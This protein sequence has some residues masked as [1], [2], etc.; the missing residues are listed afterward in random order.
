MK[1]KRKLKT[2]VILSF[3]TTLLLLSLIDLSFVAPTNS[4]FKTAGN[5]YGS[6][7]EY[8]IAFGYDV[9]FQNFYAGET[10]ITDPES[11]KDSTDPSDASNRKFTFELEIPRQIK[12]VASDI[13][14][15]N[16]DTYSFRL[17][18]PSACEIVSIDGD[19]TKKSAVYTTVNENNDE[20]FKVVIECNDVPVKGGEIKL[21]FGVNE[22]IQSDIKAFSYRD[23]NITITEEYYN[24]VMNIVTW[25]NPLTV[26][27]S[28]NV[29]R[30]TKYE[31][32]AQGYYEKYIKPY[33]TSLGYTEAESEAI[34][35]SYLHF[36]ADNTY[37]KYITD[38][39]ANAAYYGKI[40]G[41]DIYHGNVTIDGTTKNGYIYTFKDS[42]LGYIL[43]E[44]DSSPNNMYFT[45]PTVTSSNKEQ[46]KAELEEAFA[47]YLSLIYTN[48]DDYN[49]VWNY[50]EE[51]GGIYSV[52]IEGKRILGLGNYSKKSYR[53]SIS[54]D[55]LAYAI[56]L[57]DGDTVPINFN[58]DKWL[59]MDEF[60]SGI[61]GIRESIV[62]QELR[63]TSS[64]AGPLEEMILP[65]IF[66]NN[67]KD[68]PTPI[69]FIDYYII[70]DPYAKG[71]DN[72]DNPYV[73]IKAW[74]NAGVTGEEKNW[75]RFSKMEIPEEIKVSFTNSADEDTLTITIIHS[76]YDESIARPDILQVVKTFNDE[77]G[78][79]ITEDD[80]IFEETDDS[81][82]SAT[83]TISKGCGNNGVAG[84]CKVVIPGTEDT[85]TAQENQS[86]VQGEEKS[87]IT[88]SVQ[89]SI[90]K[91]TSAVDEAAESED[92]ATVDT[93]VSSS[94]PKTLYEVLVDNNKDN[95][96]TESSEDDSNLSMI[97]SIMRFMLRK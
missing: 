63:P 20:K 21:T 81:E 54:N 47:Y 32:F 82:T 71:K 72:Y 88:E 8:G 36:D 64:N 60:D 43:T 74:S 24:K 14:E 25:Q 83:Y 79:N 35:N 44:N 86:T 76:E 23:Y 69:S 48:E 41:L 1:L 89:S 77:F 5:K 95:S 11:M 7:D 42:L 49:A 52:V 45:P 27:A 2:N 62:S 46:V 56:S 66:K 9:K 73:L 31:E 10:N 80:I 90:D 30:Y 53:L 3:V 58:E 57:K 87:N 13:S 93:D 65:S 39:T 37:R 4:K 75:Y 19:T 18:L 92:L 70:S 68:Y 28:P 17:P 67:K 78:V 29:D 85:S 50:V 84:G 97:S 51:R 91:V 61:S 33:Y 26:F 59:N 94:N 16:T 96:S 15:N 12:E 22:T 6:N 38:T 55:I 34:Y 40:K